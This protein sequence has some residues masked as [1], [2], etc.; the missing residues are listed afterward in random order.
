M[1]GKHQKACQSPVG[2]RSLRSPWAHWESE[3]RLGCFL[4][5]PPREAEKGTC[6]AKQRA[7]LVLEYSAAGSCFPVPC[8]CPPDWR[9]LCLLTVS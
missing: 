3:G 2:D 4:A 7:P 6:C 9:R 8:A 1:G 5:E